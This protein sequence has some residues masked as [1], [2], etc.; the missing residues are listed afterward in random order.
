MNWKVKKFLELSTQE[1]YNILRLRA[2][3]F[4]VEQNCVYQDLDGKDENS[5]HVF[6][7]DSENIVAY[8][9]IVLPGISY[10]E[11]SIGRVVVAEEYRYQ[12]LGFNVM[13]KAI[14]VIEL[15]MGKQPIRISAQSHLEKF[16]R[17]LDFKPTGKSYLEDGIPH[18]EMLRL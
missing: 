3:I 2:A 5:I 10:Q 9:R 8:A 7:S 6:A 17:S 15:E 13:K 4:V 12:K 18:I 11:I 16:Y 14:N 1:V